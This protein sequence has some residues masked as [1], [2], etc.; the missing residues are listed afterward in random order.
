MEIRYDHMRVLRIDQTARAQRIRSLQSYYEQTQHDHHTLTWDGKPRDPGVGYMVERLTRSGFV[1]GNAAPYSNRRP[2]CP[3]PL[4]RQIITSFTDM[5]LGAGQYPTLVVQLDDDTTAFLIEVMNESDAWDTLTEARNF[6]GAGGSAAVLLSVLDGEPSTEF[7]NPAELYVPE[8]EDKKG[9]IPR[10]VIEQRLIE[11]DEIGEDGIET[12]RFWRT[13][14][15]D[16][17]FAIVYQD[18]PEDYGSDEETKDQPIP[19]LGEPVRHYAGRCP[20]VWYQNIRNSKAPEGESDLH[21]THEPIDQIDQLQ[22]MTMRASKANADPTLVYKDTDRNRRKNPHISKGHGARIDVSEQGDAKLLET[23]GSSIVTAWDGIKNVKQ[24]VLQTT[25][26]VIVDP[27]TAGT[28][29]S[30]EALQILWRRMENRSNRL[31]RPL[32]SVVRQMCRI[33]I[34]M[35]EELGIG[36][37]DDEGEEGIQ[38]DPRVIKPEPEEDKRFPA[39]DP[40]GE[41]GEEGSEPEEP[42][43]IEP[44]LQPHTLGEGRSVRVQWPP[45][46][47]PTPTQLQAM[48]AALSVATTSKQVLSQETAVAHL[49]SFIGLGDGTEELARI[50]AEKEENVA[51]F[52]APLGLGG[53]PADDATAADDTERAGE[54]PDPDDEPGAG[55]PE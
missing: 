35:A 8:W 26:C 28:Y 39:D 46:H 7:L 47:R 51:K 5:L 32:T 20:V 16:E 1:A 44:V 23:S 6:A 3:Y 11:R 53:T 54:L 33:W 12:K 29:L 2:S 52:G 25:S 19:I 14:Y 42:E 10:V 41:D 37:T 21:T 50:K 17:E 48:A 13:R 45:Y 22:S 40:E 9:W 30:G 15:W 36:S 34:A 43:E 4:G 55:D 49:S 31:R 18:V 24:E 27:E 38:L